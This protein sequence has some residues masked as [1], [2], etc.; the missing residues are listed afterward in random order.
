MGLFSKKKEEK[1]MLPDL[2]ESNAELPKLPEYGSSPGMEDLD[3]HSRV[4]VPAGGMPI[5]GQQGAIKKEI[6]SNMGMEPPNMEKSHFEP[7]PHYDGGGM[8]AKIVA[9]PSGMM[10][11]HQDWNHNDNHGLGTKGTADYSAVGH[12][13]RTVEMHEDTQ[14][15]K[16]VKSAKPIY[17]RLDKFKAGLESFQDIKSKLVEIEDLLVKIREMK[18]KEE[19]ELEEW[20][21]E[22]QVV[23]ARIEQIDNDVFRN[24]E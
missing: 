1:S 24:V 9:E 19:R 17:I 21:R 10:E 4:N 12:E 22:I 18:D 14:V 15:R 6:H 5:D 11:E 2:P 20:E 7:L 13:P 23:K 3:A 8:P 16:S